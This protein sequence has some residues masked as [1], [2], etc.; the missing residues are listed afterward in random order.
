M[1]LFYP[2]YP[3][4]KI[5]CLDGFWQF[6]FKEDFCL[7][8]KLDR[9]AIDYN[10]I[11]SVPGVFDASSDHAGRRGIG[12]YRTTFE[13][14]SSSSMMLRLGGLG[15]WGAIYIDGKRIGIDDLPYTGMD[16]EFTV[17][18]GMHELVI[19]VDNRISTDQTILFAPNYDYY[20][21]GGIYRSVELHAISDYA[22]D[23]AEIITKSLLGHFKIKLS[24]LGKP[25]DILD[26]TAQVDQKTDQRFRLPVKNNVVEFELTEKNLSL[27]SSEKPNLHLLKITAG[28]DVLTEQFG[29]RMVEVRGEDLLLNGKKLLLHGFCRHETHPEFGPALPDAVLLEDMAL[30]RQMHCNF[31]RGTHYQQDKRFL[32]LCDQFGILVWEE[33]IGWGDG[34]ERLINPLFQSGQIRQQRWIVKNSF[35]HPCVIIRGFLNEGHSEVEESRDLYEKLVHELKRLDP[36][37]PVTFASN[38]IERDLN[39][40]LADVISLNIYPGWYAKNRDCARPLSEIKTR[41][42]EVCAYLNSKDCCHKPLLISEIGAGAIYGWRDRFKTYW[43]EEYQRDY[44]EEVCKNIFANKRIS[45]VALWQFCDGKTYSG[46]YALGRPRSFNNK[47][48]LDEYRHPKLAFDVVAKYFKDAQK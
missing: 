23:R 14:Y 1:S 41:L 2:Q 6:S 43:S 31:V 46:C 42:D 28:E 12:F 16:F 13:A 44:L 10:E 20:G 27:W 47:G 40:D 36:S 18:K 24:F 8:D 33:G 25:P 5:V 21:F 9:F 37:R 45:G 19:A 39:F 34:A 26:F 30:L 15:L 35:N 3:N 4:R 48:V 29:V 38:Q 11:A 32:S 17:K 7:L 22:M